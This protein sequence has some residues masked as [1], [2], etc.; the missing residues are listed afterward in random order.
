DTQR[1][2]LVWLGLTK[3]SELPRLQSELIGSR[4]FASKQRSQAQNDLRDNLAGLPR[5]LHI[6]CLNLQHRLDETDGFRRQAMPPL[7]YRYFANMFR[8]FLGMKKNLRRGA[9]GAFVIGHNHTTLG[10]TRIDI[11]TPALL[12]SLAE[13]AGY[14]SIER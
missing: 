14:G 2:S 12:G 10:G 8:V 6:W 9:R 1:L 5:E 4:E 7:L 11:D 3:P 13:H